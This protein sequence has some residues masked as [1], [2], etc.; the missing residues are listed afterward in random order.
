MSEGHVFGQVH[1][2]LILAGHSC[3][4]ASRPKSSQDYWSKKSKTK[5]LRDCR[6][7]RDLFNEGWLVLEI[8]EC[9]I[10]R[11]RGL[12]EKLEEFMQA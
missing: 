7:R 8:W 11:M 6:I 9:G 12:V 2:R 5:W 3:A 4:V 1:A 10:R